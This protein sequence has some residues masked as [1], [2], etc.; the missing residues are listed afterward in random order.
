MARALQALIRDNPHYYEI[1]IKDDRYLRAQ[2]FLQ[3]ERVKF[4]IL[5]QYGVDSTTVDAILTAK[6]DLFIYMLKNFLSKHYI[7]FDEDL[8]HVL[9]TGK[10][11]IGGEEKYIDMTHQTFKDILIALDLDKSFF[12]NSWSGANAEGGYRKNGKNHKSRKNRKSR[13]APKR[14]TRQQKTRRNQ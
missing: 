4:K 1:M 8:Q 7:S 14:K 2:Q 11:T 13:K 3:D 12:I 6:R 9:K 10:I 5:K